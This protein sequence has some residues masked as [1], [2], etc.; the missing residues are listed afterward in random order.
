MTLSRTQSLKCRVA[1]AEIESL[2][3]LGGEG[4]FLTLWFKKTGA[5][6]QPTHSGPGFVEIG[7][8]LWR[9]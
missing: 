9:L 2:S 6:R 3:S 4:S 8:C 7:Y 5:D 1:G